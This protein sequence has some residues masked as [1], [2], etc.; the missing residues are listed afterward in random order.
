MMYNRV[1][2][3]GNLA[4]DPDVRYTPAGVP[5]TRFT[6]AV[7]RQKKSGAESEADFIPV[8]A[9]KKLAEICGEYL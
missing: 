8:V 1:F 9:W 5:V 7:N 6:V 4:R 3:I 2:I